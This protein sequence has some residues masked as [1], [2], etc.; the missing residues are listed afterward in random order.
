MQKTTDIESGTY[1]LELHANSDFSLKIKKFS[2]IT[3]PTGYYYYSGSAQKNLNSRITRHTRKDKKIYWHI[4]HLTIHPEIELTNIY[5]FPDAK[6]AFECAIISVLEKSA[7]HVAKI[8]GSSDCS[9]C[10]S[11]LLYSQKKIKLNNLLDSID[12]QFLLIHYS[13]NKIKIIRID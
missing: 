12:R 2:K 3:F 8:F 10:F 7:K 6:K 1:I 9:H 4:D 11:H 13:T 5:I